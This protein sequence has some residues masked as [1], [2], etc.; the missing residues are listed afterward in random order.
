MSHH[1]EPIKHTCP[2]IDKVIK[3]IKEIERLCS[4]RNLRGIE[5]IDDFKSII[6]EIDSELWGLQDKLEELRKSNEELRS[7]GVSE[8]KTVDKLE[9]YIEYE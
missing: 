3:S 6:S 8:A 1:R 9:S 4:D 7:W 2:D 5:E